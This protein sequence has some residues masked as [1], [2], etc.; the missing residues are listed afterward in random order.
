[1]PLTGNRDPRDHKIL[2][3]DHEKSELDDLYQLITKQYE[4][5]KDTATHHTGL[6]EPPT[7]TASTH[8]RLLNSTTGENRQKGLPTA[9]VSPTPADRTRSRAAL[10]SKPHMVPR[11][12]PGSQRNRQVPAATCSKHQPDLKPT[13]NPRLVQNIQHNQ[14]QEPTHRP[15]P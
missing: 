8:P 15:R 13:T 2:P 10:K 7:Y 11:F 4:A 9:V 1:M 3:A 5:I 6:L 14:I 12:L